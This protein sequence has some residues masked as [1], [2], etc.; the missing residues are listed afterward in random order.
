MTPKTLQA[1]I[2]IIPATIVIYAPPLDGDTLM[3]N[4]AIVTLKF[5]R[6][7]RRAWVNRRRNKWNRRR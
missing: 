2:P 6:K 7:L 3:I 4:G 1:A 5:G